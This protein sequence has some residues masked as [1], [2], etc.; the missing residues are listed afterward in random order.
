MEHRIDTGDALPVKSRYLRV[1]PL[2]EGEIRVHIEQMLGNGITRPSNS[3]WASRVILVQKKDAS[4]RF[5]IDY[6]AL[7]DLTKKDSY[8]IPEMKDILDKLQGSEYFSTLDG[9]SAYWS[10]PITE[11]DREKQLLCHKRSV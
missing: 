2:T 4:L 7:N 1:N 9:A 6:W 5:A 11:N 8:P 3:P 10:V